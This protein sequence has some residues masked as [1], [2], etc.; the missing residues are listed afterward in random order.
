M[1]DNMFFQEVYKLTKAIPRG[2]VTTYGAIARALGDP[3]K[4]SSVGWAL[5]ANKD[6]KVPCHRVVNRNG[7]LATGF[8]F[9]GPDGQKA[10]LELDGVQVESQDIENKSRYVVDLAR[11]LWEPREEN[12]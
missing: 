5:H 3:R 4:S 10:R 2:K 6:P 11:Y 12:S 1:G 8:A 9:G 7:E